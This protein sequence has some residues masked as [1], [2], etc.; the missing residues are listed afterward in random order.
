M[1]PKTYAIFRFAK[2]R[3]IPL[4][5][6]AVAYAAEE[7]GVPWR[8][9]GNPWRIE[10]GTE[11]ASIPIRGTQTPFLSSAAIRLCSNKRNTAKHL[12]QY[13]FPVPQQKIASDLQDA[14]RKAAS[15]GFPV[16]LKPISGTNGQGVS[17]RLWNHEEVAVAYRRARARNASVLVEQ[18]I[19]GNDYRFLVIGGEVAAVAHRTQ[20]RVFG[21]GRSTVEELIGFVNSDPRRS[22]GH[23]NLFTSISMD[24]DTERMLALQGM[25][26][27]SVPAEEQEVKLHSFANLSGGGTSVDVTE[28]S[29]PDNK[30][31][32]VLAASAAGV[33][34]AGV[35]FLCK[36]VSKSYLRHGGAICEINSIPG[37]RIHI[38]PVGGKLQD[39]GGAVV[40]YLLKMLDA[41]TA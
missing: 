23:Q 5:T 21:D 17:V 26:Y 29:H 32:A 12:S 24:D 39:V 35:D 40:R 9:V 20:A 41:K 30:A 25:T 33:P 36:D 28:I 2:D 3:R 37:L 18:W 1:N 31:L 8:K 10:V 7:M 16:V 22:P 19:E 4:G 15:I 6:A 34:M 11:G 13:G 27:A 14:Q 38:T